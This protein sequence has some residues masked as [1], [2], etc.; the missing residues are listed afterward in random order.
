LM[1]KGYLN[2]LGYRAKNIPQRFRQVM[3]G[4]E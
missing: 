4:L 2:A 1:K 3:K